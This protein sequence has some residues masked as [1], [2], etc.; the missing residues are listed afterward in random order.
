MQSTLNMR[1]AIDHPDFKYWTK[2]IRPNSSTKVS[3]P[4][5]RE[6]PRGRSV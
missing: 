2:A 5:D 4:A 1:P 3:D 6:V